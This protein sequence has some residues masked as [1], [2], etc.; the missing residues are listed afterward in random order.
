MTNVGHSAIR[1]GPYRSRHISCYSNVLQWPSMGEKEKES[2]DSIICSQSAIC[3]CTLNNPTKKTTY[4][5]S[6]LL[7]MRTSEY[8]IEQHTWQPN[9]S[10]SQRIGSRIVQ[11]RNRLRNSHHSINWSC[12]DH[13]DSFFIPSLYSMCGVTYKRS[14]ILIFLSTYSWRTPRSNFKVQHTHIT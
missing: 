6:N 4:Y 10:H 1:D 2:E 5:G 3:E 14:Y 11:E 12:Q 7:S 13:V 8:D 9:D